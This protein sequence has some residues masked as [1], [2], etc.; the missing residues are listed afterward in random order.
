MFY[1]LPREYIFLNDDINN[2]SEFEIKVKLTENKKAE[3][4]IKYLISFEHLSYQTVEYYTDLDNY[5]SS[6]SKLAHSLDSTMN[7][8]IMKT[9]DVPNYVPYVSKSY[10]KGGYGAITAGSGF[11]DSIIYNTKPEVESR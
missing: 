11:T 10:V 9:D 8:D 5:Y 7:V 4:P 1:G 3:Y 6:Y 2:G